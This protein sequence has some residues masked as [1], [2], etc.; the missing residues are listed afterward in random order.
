MNPGR[1]GGEKDP[2]ASVTRAGRGSALLKEL[3]ELLR[4]TAERRRK[5]VIVIEGPS[6]AAEILAGPYRVVQALA[7]PRL[8]R[9]RE[10]GKVLEA[11]GRLG[12]RVRRVEDTVL[13]SLADVEAARGI[14]LIVERPHWDLETLL[15]RAESPLVLVAQGIQDPGNL[16]ALARV[17]DAAWGT[18]LLCIGGADPWAPR[19]VRAGAG[20]IPRFPVLEAARAAPALQSIR[21]A[22]L[23]LIG[24]S[25]HDGRSYIEADLGGPAA[26][27][28]GTEGAG[29]PTSVI[30]AMDFM[31]SVP[32][33]PGVESLNVVSAAAVIL[34]HRS[35][36]HP[37][38][39]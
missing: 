15:A 39:R 37:P 3:K 38:A 19:S 28:V 1:Q 12:E 8:A 25:P 13:A 36:R 21:K 22:G 4:S 29:L 33:R 34:F 32:L 11:L 30:D 18:A 27:V 9:E 26:L 16:G 2:L 24:A 10:G 14:L 35:L 20:S 6:L 7:S 31:V 5:K 23:R 17:A